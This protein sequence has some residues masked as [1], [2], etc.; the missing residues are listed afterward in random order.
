MFDP[1]LSV[2]KP[3]VAILGRVAIRSILEQKLKLAAVI[4]LLVLNTEWFH[5]VWRS[6]HAW[7]IAWFAGSLLS[8]SQHGC[9]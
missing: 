6:P 7:V 2:Y 5:P 8:Q 1:R 4:K 9:S 3:P